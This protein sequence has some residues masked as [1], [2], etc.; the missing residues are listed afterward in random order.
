MAVVEVTSGLSLEEHL[1]I[2]QRISEL[3]GPVPG[4][5]LQICCGEGDDLLIV[6]VYESEADY[7]AFTE[8][9]LAK[10]LA[11]L[12]YTDISYEGHLLPAHD[13]TVQ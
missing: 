13:V 11:D 2:K 12:S 9:V 10:V 5:L 8:T 4:R 6:T 7:D 3:Y 1:T